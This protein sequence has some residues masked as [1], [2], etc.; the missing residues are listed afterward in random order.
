MKTTSLK[1][2]GF[3]ALSMHFRNGTLNYD[4]KFTDASGKEWKVKI[5]GI[6]TAH[7]GIT[8]AV[9]GDRHDGRTAEWTHCWEKVVDLKQLSYLS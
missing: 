7:T 8:I 1:S 3:R 4:R 5:I 9:D 2:T 6:S